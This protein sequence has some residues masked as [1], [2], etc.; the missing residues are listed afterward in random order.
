MTIIYSTESAAIQ[1]LSFSATSSISSQS[2]LLRKTTVDDFKRGSC[3]LAPRLANASST[4][5]G[6]L[7]QRWKTAN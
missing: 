6:E 5:T 1:V 4:G 2:T 3:I 7:H